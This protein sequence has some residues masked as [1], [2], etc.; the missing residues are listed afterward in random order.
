MK[1]LI[2]EDNKSIVTMFK[3]ALEAHGMQVTTSLDGKEGLEL[4]E[5][6]KFDAILLDL[7]MPD[8]SG[9][10]ILDTLE[11]NGKLKEQK[12]IVIT[13]SILANDKKNNL[14]RRGIFTIFY[15]P[16]DMPILLSTIKSMN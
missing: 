11:K 9:Y 12:I 10:D 15:K 1:I 14:I 6:E 7:A 8:F 2:V 5:K 13:A 16:V 3:I 4:I